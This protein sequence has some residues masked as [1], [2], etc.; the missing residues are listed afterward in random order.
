VTVHFVA[1]RAENCFEI[2][3]AWLRR[4][5]LHGHFKVMSLASYFTLPR[6]ET[7]TIA[8]SIPQ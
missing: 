6:S 4:A 3:I 1:C 2:L 8:G 7:G 5:D